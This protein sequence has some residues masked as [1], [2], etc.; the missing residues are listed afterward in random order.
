MC[1]T[2]HVTAMGGGGFFS[3]KKAPSGT[4]NPTIFFCFARHPP[5]PP[6]LFFSCFFQCTGYVQG[7]QA[8][9]D[10]WATTK[11]GPEK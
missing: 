7:L 3:L 6:S 9:T 10:R 2:W 11:Q 1:Q 4:N 8:R 5:P